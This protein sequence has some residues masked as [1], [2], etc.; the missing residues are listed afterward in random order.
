LALT[1]RE[2]D[3]L[4]S[5]NFESGVDKPM[6]AFTELMK[7]LSANGVLTKSPTPR[8][9][10][11]MLKA[12]KVGCD[13]KKAVENIDRELGIGAAGLMFPHTA[14]AKEL[15]AGL[16]AMRFKSKG[17]TRPD[18][19]GMA[20]SIWGLTPQQYKDKA[21][22]SSLNPNGELVNFTIVED[23]DGLAHVREIAAVKGIGVL[24]PGAGTLGGVFWKDDGQG[25]WVRD[26]EAWEKAIQQVLAACKEFNVPCGYPS[27]TWDD[28]R[29]GMDKRMKQ[30]FSV[31]VS[32]WADAG[33]SAINQGRKA[34][35]RTETTNN[36]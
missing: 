9:M 22:L 18:D 14:S 33:F 28:P 35:G 3:Y 12:P 23:K 17:G 4:F 11:I 13:M 29:G 16:A 15:Q 2:E 30:G 26:D 25:N 31:F 21:D 10:P 32:G 8:M 19:T 20:P 27:S 5:G 34:S 24:W 7:G 6:P 36:H 1:H